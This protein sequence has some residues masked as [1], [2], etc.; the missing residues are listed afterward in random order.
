M[1]FTYIAYENIIRELNDNEYD[2][3]D[4][5]NWSKYSHS[6]ILRHDIDYDISKA[7]QL[8]ALENAMGVKS[9]Y[10]VLLTS[11]FYNVFSKES[12]DGL[13]KIMNYGHEIGL[14]FDE[15]RYQDC[16]GDTDRV[17]EHILEETRLL[18]KCIGKEVNVVSMHRPSRAVLDANLQIPDMINSYSQTFFKEFKY[19]SDSRRQWREPIEEIIQSSEHERLHILTHAFW[20]NDDEQDIHDSV[21]EFINSGNSNRWKWMLSNITDLETIMKSEEIVGVKG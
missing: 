11:D 9:T 10:F 8:A 14:H 3:T 1:E 19:L 20:Y 17:V 4:Y 12:Y 2:F 16:E 21:S 6:V 18:G 13:M 7:I 15:V 5:H